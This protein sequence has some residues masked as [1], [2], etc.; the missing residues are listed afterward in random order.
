[1][2]RHPISSPE[3]T[4]CSSFPGVMAVQLPQRHHVDSVARPPMRLLVVDDE[5]IQRM[6]I[7][8]AVA[9]L[10][11]AVDTAADLS[12]AAAHLAEY[13]YDAV[14][15]DLSLG[16]SEGISLLQSLRDA[17]SDP[18][19]IFI[20]R[21]DERVRTASVRLATTMGLRVA[22]TLQKPASPGALLVLCCATHRP[23][24]SSIASPRR[25][26]RVRLSS[27]VRSGPGSSSRTSSPRSRCWTDGSW[28]SRRWRA[29]LAR[30][31]RVCRRTLSCRWRNAPD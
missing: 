17:A 12:D 28:G 25:N 4:G 3:F 20:S 8:R 7:V 9:P 29:G 15:L 18:I 14:I 1:M 19:L 26:R 23:G 22:G 2:G 11:Y 10:G 6:I 21:L 13:R 31:A 27:P 30:M 16:E 24:K 5:R